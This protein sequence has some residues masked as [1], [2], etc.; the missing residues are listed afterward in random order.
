MKSI[1]LDIGFTILLA[2]TIVWIQ[3]Q[4]VSPVPLSFQTQEGETAPMPNSAIILFWDTQVKASHR[5]IQ[6]I[7]RFHQAH[8][9]IET[10]FIHDNTQSETVLRDFLISL[11]VY[12][13]PLYSTAWPEHVPMS[14]LVHQGQRIDLHHSP[15]YSQLMEFF[16]VEF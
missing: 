6:L 5:D 10:L 4:P 8:P 1:L 15:H 2:T 12:T 9:N 3:R 16:G 7:Q 14:I 13:T 11:G